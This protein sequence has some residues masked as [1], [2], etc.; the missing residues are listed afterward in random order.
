[1]SDE[2]DRLRQL[3]R[4]IDLKKLEL[5]QARAKLQ[6][7]LAFYT[8]EAEQ[9]QRLQQYAQEYQSTAA[10]SEQPRLLAMRGAFLAQI[11]DSIAQQQRVLG[12]AQHRVDSAQAQWYRLRK[13]KEMLEAKVSDLENW[14]LAKSEKQLDAETQA[15]FQHRQSK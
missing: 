8:R 12:A 3:G 2:A 13:F 1:M 15:F 14:R 11:H 9:L 7:E 10:Q 6:D 5:D 4:L